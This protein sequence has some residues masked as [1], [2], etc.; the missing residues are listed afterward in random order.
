[1]IRTLIWLCLAAPL[2]PAA[3]RFPEAA[4]DSQA[5]RDD[6]YRQ[7]DR[8]FEQQIAA[9][10]KQRAQYWSRLDFSSPASFDRSVQRY[11]DD[12]AK[13]IAVPSPGDT[14]L[15]VKQVKVHDFDT[16]TGYRVWFDTVPG[17]QAYGILL[18]PKKAGPKPALV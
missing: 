12:W 14:P 1:M 18:V 3:E 10:E 2:L 4:S 6:Q 17:V 7:M 9:A 5:I 16:Y 11:R 8:Y 15:H 13:F